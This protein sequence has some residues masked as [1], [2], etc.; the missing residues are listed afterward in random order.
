MATPGGENL[1][2]I[3][4]ICDGSNTKAVKTVKIYFKKELNDGKLS[5]KTD[6]NTI[7]IA[8]GYGLI[9]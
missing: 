2:Y 4:T 3:L 6:R 8:V 9:L 5:C 1:N 7:F